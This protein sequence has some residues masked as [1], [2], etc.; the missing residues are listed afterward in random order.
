LPAGSAALRQLIRQHYCSSLNGVI[1]NYPAANDSRT[2]VRPAARA[3]LATRPNADLFHFIFSIW[4]DAAKGGIA[5]K[6]PRDPATDTAR[7]QPATADA[8]VVERICRAVVDG[9]RFSRA[10]A[11]WCKRFGLSEPEFQVL[12]WLH[13]AAG[14]GTDQSTLAK[15]LALSPAQV[16]ATVERLRT[17]GWIAQQSRPHDRRR[18]FWQL[19]DG[20]RSLVERMLADAGELRNAAS[21]HGDSLAESGLPV[22]GGASKPEAEAA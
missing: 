3:S 9:R 14:S 8:R 21:R 2:N 12:R 16:S 11:H 7:G 6:A 1:P 20:G 4:A 5:V 19:S 10:L 18:N 22:F 13:E 17:Q 15:G